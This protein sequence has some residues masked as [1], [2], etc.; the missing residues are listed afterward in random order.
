ML[1][2]N[3]VT[4][5]RSPEARAPR[6]TRVDRKPADPGRYGSGPGVPDAAP[7]LVSRI[8]MSFWCQP[9]VR[10]RR[11]QQQ[12]DSDNQPA[13]GLNTAPTKAELCVTL[14]AL[15]LAAVA[16]ILSAPDH[17]NKMHP[18]SQ[19]LTA[20]VTPEAAAIAGAIGGNPDVLQPR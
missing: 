20:S 1:F 12:A 16:A 17:P 8:A 11:N 9:T 4:S 5:E 13:K 10:D 2:R 14:L 6:H 7:P 19:W 3:F 18:I 15:A